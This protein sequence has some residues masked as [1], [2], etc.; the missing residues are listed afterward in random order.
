MSVSDLMI[1]GGGPAGLTAAIA[2]KEVEPTA[3]ITIYEKNSEVGKK[4]LATG[5]GRCN[6]A[7]TN[8]VHFDVTRSFLERT[9]IMLK[10]EEDGRVYPNSNSAE[11][12]RDLLK[13]RA[14]LL[15]IQIVCNSN[16]CDAKRMSTGE[17]A[18][19][20]CDKGKKIT[21]YN[22]HNLLIAAGGKAAPQFGSTGDGYIIAKKLGH[23]VTPLRPSLSAF[24]CVGDFSSLKGVRA[25]AIV[26]L[27]ENTEISRQVGEI[28]FT[29]YGLS[30]ICI[31]NLS[32]Y[33]VLK[34]LENR[35]IAEAFK[36]F[37]VQV[38]FLPKYD[39]RT[40]RKI[41]GDR[42]NYLGRDS[43]KDI[44]LGILPKK[45]CTY[46]LKKSGIDLEVCDENYE[47]KFIES[48]I[49]NIKT[50]KFKIKSVRGWKYAQ[51]TA[52]GI[53]SNELNP[54]TFESKLMSGLYFAGEILD[55]DGICGGYNLS[56]AFYSAICAGH[57]VAK[58]LQEKI[59]CRK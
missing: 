8:Y 36:D 48:V 38:D 17:F 34:N 35:S 10:E 2:C 40:L 59:R 3:K 24:E 25:D 31:F 46:I 19:G 12:V 9:H 18:V 6:I 55:Y 32:K 16:M 39:E 58:T 20:I 42:L 45:L 51:C 15:G 54:L 43:E 52:G 49:N 1:M 22:T 11:D 7:N 50:A 13:I 21:Y 29:E 5:N 23:K 37:Y 28:Q 57:S 56:N 4:I 26:K 33:L 41:L 53:M 47:S 27:F 30:G 44:L 14:E